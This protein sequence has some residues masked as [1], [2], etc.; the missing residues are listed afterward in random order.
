MSIDWKSRALEMHRRAQAA[1]AKLQ[2][3]K[4]WIEAGVNSA[5]GIPRE[6]SVA[7]LSFAKQEMERK[8]KSE[9]QHA[10]MASE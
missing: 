9:K 2:R 10:L 6:I 7:Y 4:W 1:E 8:T 5:A 3:A